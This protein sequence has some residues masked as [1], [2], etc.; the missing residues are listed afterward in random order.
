VRVLAIPGVHSRMGVKEFDAALKAAGVLP[1]YDWSYSKDHH[2]AWCNFLDI[3]S[4]EDALRFADENDAHRRAMGGMGSD[5]P[6]QKNY[7][8]REWLAKPFW[9]ADVSRVRQVLACSR[10]ICC[11]CHETGSYKPKSS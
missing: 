6:C 2:W 1:N 4:V 11:G 9:R 5:L 8:I 10:R 3:K 7:Q